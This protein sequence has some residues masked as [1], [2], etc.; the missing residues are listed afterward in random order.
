ML[1]TGFLILDAGEREKSYEE[2][3]V[4]TRRSKKKRLKSGVE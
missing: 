4:V 3:N 2:L 1:D